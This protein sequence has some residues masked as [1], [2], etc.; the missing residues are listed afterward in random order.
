MLDRAS[1][2]GSSHNKA[3]AV[4]VIN[5][6]FLLLGGDNFTS[7][8]KYISYVNSLP[9][10]TEDQE[11]DL[12]DKF[13]NYNNKDAGQQIIMSHLRLVVKIAMEFRRYKMHMMEMIAEGNYGLLKALQKFDLGKG[14][15]F[16]TYAM[17]W[18]KS[19][20]QDFI[21]K[22]RSIIKIGSTA[23][24]KKIIYNLA[25]VK[26]AL[27]V[28]DSG[29]YNKNIQ[30]I[31]DTFGT[32][33]R[34]LEYISNVMSGTQSLNTKVFDDEVSE[35]I[36]VI[37]DEDN[38]SPEALTLTAMDS[39]ERTLQAALFSLDERERRIITARRLTDEPAT[40]KDL[41]TELN[42]SQERVRQIE[43]K[44][45]TKLKKF[46]KDRDLTS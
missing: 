40:L 29:S 6:S 34:E 12:I 3:D 41:S 14:V 15:R 38:Q 27:G 43:E 19:Y 36:D 4:A 32:S 42:V 1:R 30:E 11:N 39:P 10:L 26:T 7:I 33:T 46:L 25:K 45:L 9:M 44:A 17:L 18:I 8:S 16:S 22:N 2:R 23:L 37:S 21:V 13:Y 31:A 24:Q 28:V 35:L 20:I 5:P